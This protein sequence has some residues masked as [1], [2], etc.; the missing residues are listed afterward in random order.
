[1]LLNALQQFKGLWTRKTLEE[2]PQRLA[3]LENLRTT[4]EGGLRIRAGVKKP[5]PTGGTWTAASPL[6]GS[7][8]TSMVTGGH[9]M[10]SSWPVLLRRT[11]AGAFSED[12]SQQAYFVLFSTAA[13]GE[14]FY[15][16]SPAGKFSIFT[17]QI[18]RINTNCTI[19]WKYLDTNGAAQTL[20]GVTEQFT[21][22]GERP[23]RFSPPSD[24]GG[25]FVSGY[26]GY[27]VYAE[28]TAVGG[29]P[30]AP[31]NYGIQITGDFPARTVTLVSTSN[32][33]SSPTTAKLW[34]FAS[35]N[36]PPLQTKWAVADGVSALDAGNDSPVSIASHNGVAYW[37]NGQVQR[38]YQ[39]DQNLAATIGFT[40]PGGT[41][42][43]A[44]SAGNVPA[45]TYTYY[46]T[47]G[48][49]PAGAW[50]QS[51][52]TKIGT[53]TS[54]APFGVNLN[55]DPAD[56]ALYDSGIVDCFFIYRTWDLTG[57]STAFY[58]S[59]PA[60]L[61]AQVFRQPGDG[62]YPVNGIGNVGY[63]DWQN[64][65][66]ISPL[67]NLD[68]RDRTPPRN[69]KLMLFHKNRLLLANGRGTPS[70]VWPSLPGEY[71]AFDTLSDSGFQDFTTGGGDE[72]TGMA[73]YADMAVVFTQR[74]MYGIA[75]LETP[76][77]W[78]P[79]TIHPEIGCVAPW[80][81]VVAHGV[82]FWLSEA[83]PMMWDGVNP[84]Q[85]LG[86]PVRLENCSTL[87]HGMSRGVGYDF[88]Y[89]L[90]LIPQDRG[91]AFANQ[92]PSALYGNLFTKYFYSLRTGEWSKTTFS[93]SE[94]DYMQPICSVR[95]PH[96]TDYEGR[97][98]PVYGRHR[99]GGATTDL[100]VWF[101]EAGINDDGTTMQCLWEVPYG[102][103]KAELMVPELWELDTLGLGS[104][105]TSVN[106]TLAIG[107]KPVLAASP[108]GDDSDT[109]T[110]YVSRFSTSGTGCAAINLRCTANV[111]A[112]LERNAYV[113][114]AFLHGKKTR[115]KQPG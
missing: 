74:A 68:T 56:L 40:K 54:G 95:W 26:Y 93:N 75:G 102:P 4:P 29:G 17:P 50:G 35:E 59:V 98:A 28:I 7:S 108:T 66:L 76:D 115:R 3:D 83:G 114:S 55:I 5:A 47:Y 90:E 9:Q 38:R 36:T 97:L 82:L 86:W 10:R 31:R 53:F 88:G 8:A 64:L 81:I 71:E 46:V 73:D 94:K 27:A 63:Q 21:A 1:V 19:A 61:I 33:L 105:A 14:R 11:A 113:F 80:S 2:D 42:T 111:T 70:R 89:E 25:N 16:I 45:G 67:V 60:Y 20:P 104:L 39:G 32:S 6:V 34:R 57:A 112:S 99:W 62:T 85:P 44:V 52:P 91:S 106:T 100:A 13:V 77:D 43:G 12:I 49:G 22:L 48:Y 24:W 72:V 30:I 65:P 110:S 103:W 92:W 23:I 41:I 109:L 51:P 18:G 87:V 78:Y 58:D 79:I 84:P 69:A 15:V 96:G 101:G 107:E 37:T